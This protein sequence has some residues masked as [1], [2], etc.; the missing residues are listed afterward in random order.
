MGL[1][2]DAGWLFL[3]A[4]ALLETLAVLILV[5]PMPSNKFRGFFVNSF[6]QIWANSSFLRSF[7]V[8]GIGVCSLILITITRRNFFVLQQSCP[9]REELYVSSYSLF[10]FIILRR[11]LNIQR[12]LHLSRDELKRAE[13]STDWIELESVPRPNAS[14]PPMDESKKT[15]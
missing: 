12:L 9:A 5:M 7:M 14:A 11:L 2:T 15:K 1:T 6:L 8:F 13:I 4:F 10:M 3:Y